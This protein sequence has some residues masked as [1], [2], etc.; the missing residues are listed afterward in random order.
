MAQRHN[1]AKANEKRGRR[2]EWE[3]G[4]IPPLKSLSRD[5]GRVRG[6][7]LEI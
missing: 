5:S 3:S 4:R 1:G 6:M 2:G 7:F